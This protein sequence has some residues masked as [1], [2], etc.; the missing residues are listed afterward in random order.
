MRAWWS[1]N[2]CP[3]PYRIAGDIALG[4][5][6][7]DGAWDTDDIEML[8]S[9]FLINEEALE[10][11]A[12]GSLISRLALMIQ[13]RIVRRNSVRG[14]KRNIEAHYDVGNDFYALWLD[15]SMTYSSGL[16]GDTAKALED[17]QRNKYERILE[18]SF[19]PARRCW[20]SA[21]VGAALPSARLS[22]ATR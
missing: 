9:L 12:R 11:Y 15:K 5:E 17:A 13:D 6:Y 10:K 16:F 21:A 7:V 14:A 8:V 4:E 19:S 3:E 20:R 1:T 22:T 2:G 18:N